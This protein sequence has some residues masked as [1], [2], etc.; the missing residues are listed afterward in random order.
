MCVDQV[1]WFNDRGLIGPICNIL[2]AEAEECYDA[3]IAQFAMAA[4]LDRQCLGNPGG[5]SI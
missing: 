1:D 2:P 4:W 5:D 3:M